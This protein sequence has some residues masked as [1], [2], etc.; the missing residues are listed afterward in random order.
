MSFSWSSYQFFYLWSSSADFLLQASTSPSGSLSDLLTLWCHIPCKDTCLKCWIWVIYPHL[1]EALSHK[2]FNQ[3]SFGSCMVLYSSSS[4]C[5]M[6]PLGTFPS[7][8]VIGLDLP[9][10]IEFFTYVDQLYVYTLYCYSVAILWFDY[11][12]SSFL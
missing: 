6:S 8:D 2:N 11:E 3:I 10:Q 9:F 1:L 5:Y 12:A 7:W 4:V